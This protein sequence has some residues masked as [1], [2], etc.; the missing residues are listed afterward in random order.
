MSEDGTHVVPRNSSAS[1]APASRR[2]SVRRAEFRA[3]PGGRRAGVEGA[4]SPSPRSYRHLLGHGKRLPVAV[5]AIARE[6]LGF[7]WVAMVGS[8]RLTQV[9]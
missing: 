5:V 1:S 8:N 9:P 3:T 4:A 6:L 2:P 7:L